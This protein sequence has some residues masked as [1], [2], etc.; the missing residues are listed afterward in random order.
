MGGTDACVASMGVFILLPKKV[1]GS[2]GRRL[3][4]EGLSIPIAYLVITVWR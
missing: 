1:L 4:I 2:R 3:L